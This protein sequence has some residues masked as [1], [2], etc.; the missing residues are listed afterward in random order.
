MESLQDKTDEVCP[1]LIGI[2]ESHL[3]EEEKLKFDGYADPF[4][5]DRDNLGGGIC[6]AV[7]QEIKDICTVV[8]KWR[9]VGES[10]WIVIDNGIVKVRVGVVYAP[11]ES[12]TS[13][14]KLQI[15]YK[16]ISEQVQQARERNQVLLILGNFNGKIGKEVKGN[17]PEVTKGGTLLL[18]KRN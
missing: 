13:A 6:I 12:R 2:T 4:R 3:L 7:R 1:T 11:Q 5:N 14:E 18:N 15:F 16:H 17:K 9:D 10:L 8:E